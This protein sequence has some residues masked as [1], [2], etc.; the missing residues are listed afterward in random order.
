MTSQSSYPKAKNPEKCTLCG[1]S[2]EKD[3]RDCAFAYPPN[4]YLCFDCFKKSMDAGISRLNKRLA[5]GDLDLSVEEISDIVKPQSSPTTARTPTEG[6]TPR[7]Y[8]PAVLNGEPSGRDSRCSTP[9][10]SE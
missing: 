1:G 10:A 2:F 9:R 7:I 5:M 4:H 3:G 6:D 8:R